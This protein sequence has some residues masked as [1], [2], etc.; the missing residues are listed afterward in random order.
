MKYD[1]CIIGHGDF[2]LGI[3]SAVEV[4]AGTS[5]KITCFNLNENITHEQFE[6]SINQ[7]IQSHSYVIFF[8]DIVGGAPCQIV[9][10][11]I[12]SQKDSNKCI[13]AGVSLSL[14]LDIYLKN[15]SNKLNP[16]NLDDS[17]KD[18]I[19]D[20]KSLIQEISYKQDLEKEC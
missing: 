13:V 3:K 20:S 12:L 16:Q 18:V 9:A 5:N 4:I 6:M 15:M 11:K 2:P 1:I 10:Q 17:I 19:K 14:V 7:Y 8:V